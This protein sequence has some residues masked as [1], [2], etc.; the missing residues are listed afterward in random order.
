MEHECEVYTNHNWCTWYNPQRIN[1]GTGG[2]GNK[3]TSGNY[4]NYCITE[5]GQN[6]EKCPGDLGRLAVTQT[7]RKDHQLTLM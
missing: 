6:T 3:R 7:P 5:V 2:L 4:P 1:K